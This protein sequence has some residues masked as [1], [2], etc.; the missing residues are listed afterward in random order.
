MQT[1]RRRRSKTAE[2]CYFLHYIWDEDGGKGPLWAP[3]K[4]GDAGLV[5]RRGP[6]LVLAPA[7]GVWSTMPSYS[8]RCGRFGGFHARGATLALILRP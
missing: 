4:V 8:E 6:A 5:T 1:Q 7:D 3:P 2:G